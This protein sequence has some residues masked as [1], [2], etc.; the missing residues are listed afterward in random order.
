MTQNTTILSEKESSLLE[1]LIAQYGLVV[2]FGQIQ[3]EL[4]QN[5]SRQQVRNL[6][7]KMT[8]NGWLVRIK[9]GVYYI[10]SLESRGFA[11][12]SVLVVA[13]IILDE[14]YVS[15]ES[16]L[17]QYGIFDQHIRTVSSVCLKKK[18]E[19]TIQGITYRFI[20]TSKKN[21]YG[22]EE[23]QIEGRTVKIATA[24]KAILDMIRSRRSIHSLDE[25]LEKLRECKDNFDFGKLQ[26]FSRG[27]SLTVQKILGF[28][29]DRAEVNSDSTHHLIKGKKGV[30]FMT[31]DSKVFNA[32]WNLYYHVHFS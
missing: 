24:E 4:I 2:D 6:V 8:K 31:R 10:T 20:K 3:R 29:L 11:G 7:A 5:Y 12:A 15:F 9:K 13:Q 27:Q 14:S 30:S 1:S 25:V 23:T 32:K 18:T 28:L 21:F 16:A 17:Q 19:K 22:W 26:E